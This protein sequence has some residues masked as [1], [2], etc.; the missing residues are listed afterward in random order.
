MKTEKPYETSAWCYGAGDVQRECPVCKEALHGGEH[1]CV[2][3][4]V[5]YH[6]ECYERIK[7]DGK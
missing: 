1:I 2:L 4:G 7:E 5:V 3:R 6:K